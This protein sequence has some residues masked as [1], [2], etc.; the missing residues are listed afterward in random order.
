MT[1]CKPKPAPVSCK[2][3]RVGQALAYVITGKDAARR[4]TDFNP[5]AARLPYQFF[6]VERD[7]VLPFYQH[8]ILDADIGL[9]MCSRS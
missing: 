9:W 6:Q 1:I 7:E 8:T 4:N 5:A 3:Q 2:M